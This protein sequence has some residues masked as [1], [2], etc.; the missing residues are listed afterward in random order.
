M[1]PDRRFGLPTAML[2]VVASMVGTGVFTTTG[3]LLRDIRSI[4]AVLV[5]WVLGGVVA[6]FGALAYGELCA[7]LPENGGEY[8]LLSD[9]Y[10]PAVGFTAGVTSSVV[11][12]SAP[13]AAS[14][15]AFDEY[16]AIALGGHVVPAPWPAIALVVATSVVHTLRVGAGS[17]FQNVFTAGK[18][19]LVV[20]FVVAGAFAGHVGLLGEGST[21]ALGDAL[22]TPAFAVGLVFISYSYSGWNAAAYVAGEVDRP[23]RNLPLALALGTG[24]VMLL[25]VA[26][27]AVF[28][29]SA[30]AAELAA[31]ESHVGAVAAVALFG[32]S[33]GRVLAG[34]IALGLVSTVGALVMTGPRVYEAMGRDYPELRALALRRAGGGPGVAIVIQAAFALVMVANASFDTLLEYVGFTLAI[35][36]ALTVAGV[37]VLR[38]RETSTEVPY[39]T[40]GH[41]FTT[42][43]FILL[44]LWMVVYALVERPLVGLTG[45]GTLAAGLLLYAAL[46]RASRAA[47]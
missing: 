38:R 10:H 16:L 13:I 19:L 3:Y 7:A 14:A 36:S 30:P 28:L 29:A 8:K 47:P 46:S 24:L 32:E 26:I 35:F 2:L 45:L 9:L 37:F 12:F 41:P 17:G 11:G 33:A 5:A 18:I 44:S 43:A 22:A 31:S 4:P 34:I 20:G 15:I 25:Y 39:R 27:N 21:R 1:A 42:G 23:S 6:L 40:W